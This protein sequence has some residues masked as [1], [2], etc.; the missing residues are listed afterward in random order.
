VAV[1]DARV[2]VFGGAALAAYGF[3]QSHPFN[4][5]RHDTFFQALELEGLAQRTRRLAPVRATRAQLELFHDPRY[6][7]LVAARC[8][9]G[10][11]YLDGGDTPAQRGLDEAAAVVVG[12]TLEACRRVLAGE[13]ARSFCPVG[14]LHH[15]ARD[16][17]AGFCVYNDCGVAIEWLRT[18]G[19]ERI[20]YVDIDAHHGDGVFY[21]F[22]DDPELLFADIHQD[23]RTLYPGTGAADETGRGAARGTKLNL[24]LAPGADDAAFRRAWQEVERYL[25]AT[26]PEFYI[27]QCG[28]DSLAD[29]PLAQLALTPASHAHAAA[30]LATLA[31]RPGCRGLVAVGGG[32]YSRDNIAAAWTG[33]VRSL[34]EAPAR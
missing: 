23:G 22:E 29:D 34:L 24:P 3:G 26:P 10:T 18:Q 8:A 27:M 13:V 12:T 31:A 15:G 9:E 4:T 5:R 1:V 21:A 17:A 7:D 19:L 6:L 16:R 30:R 33:V 20:A 14:G 25:E 28:A 11:G 32:G 2:G